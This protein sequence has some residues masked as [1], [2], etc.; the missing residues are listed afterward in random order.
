MEKISPVIRLPPVLLL[1]ASY[2]LLWLFALHEVNVAEQSRFEARSPYGAMNCKKLYFSERLVPIMP[3]AL[4]HKS[5]NKSYH[6]PCFFD[7][8]VLCQKQHSIPG[9]VE[10]LVQVFCI[11]WKK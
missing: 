1:W 7:K 2:G 11:S 3:H 10:I 6:W 9:K 5:P 8:A 4:Y